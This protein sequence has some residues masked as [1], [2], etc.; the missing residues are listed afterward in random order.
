[1]AVVVATRK[2]CHTLMIHMVA[3]A[4]CCVL[5]SCLH[6]LRR[7]ISLPHLPRLLIVHPQQCPCTPCVCV[8]EPGMGRF[9]ALAGSSRIW[10]IQSVALQWQSRHTATY[11]SARGIF[12][13][14][15]LGDCTVLRRLLEHLWTAA[16]ALE[17]ALVPA[18]PA[19]RASDHRCVISLQACNAMIS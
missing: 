14:K 3:N 7:I 1:M 16:W 8:V 18:L 19:T 17:V 5:S 4:P 6:H 9:T 10:T 11:C 15:F 13:C 12:S 2:C